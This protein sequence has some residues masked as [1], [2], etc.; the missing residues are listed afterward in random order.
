MRE[1]RVRNVCGLTSVD[2]GKAL[3]ADV[4]HGATEA[5][6]PQPGRAGREGGREGGE[7]ELA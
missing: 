4:G 3:G 1:E 7:G 2:V 5:G 6:E